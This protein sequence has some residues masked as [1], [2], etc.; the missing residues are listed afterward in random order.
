LAAAAVVDEAVVARM[1]HLHRGRASVPARKATA[2]APGGPQPRFHLSM[3]PSS[4]R[5]RSLQPEGDV[6]AVERQRGR[7]WLQKGR[8][9][10]C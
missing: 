2:A 6:E 9:Q 5:S 1:Q 3:S 10:S 7:V 4:V 8:F